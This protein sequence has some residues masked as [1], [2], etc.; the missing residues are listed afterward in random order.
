MS[1]YIV[2]GKVP[3]GTDKISSIGNLN[4][5]KSIDEETGQKSLWNP[6]IFAGM[7]IY[8]RVDPMSIHIDTAI[9]Y[10]SR[11]LYQF[12]WYFLLGGIG[13]F[14]FLKQ[15]K[16]PWY[17][18]VI[19]TVAFIMLP[20]W[21]AMLGNGHFSKIRAIMVLPWLLA[22][23]DYFIEKK[24]WFSA[25]LFALAFSWLVRTHHFQIVFYGIV[26]L[27]FLYAFPIL[28]LSIE[29]KYKD[30]GNIMLKLTAAVI[31]TIMTAA[32]PM[33]STKEYADYSTRGGNPVELGNEA[34]TAKKSG[35]VSFEYATRWSLAPREIIDFFIPRF[36]GGTSAEVY[37]GE[38]Y[39]QVKG[40]R[41]PG[42][43]GEMP[44]TDNYDAMGMILFL[45][46]VIG[47]IHFR[48]NPFVA[49]LGIF[50]LFSVLLALGRHF[51]FFYDIFFNYLPYFSK[52]RVPVMFAH[53][54]FIATFILS[55][56]GL[57]AVFEKIQKKEFNTVY[58]VL[59]G[60]ILFTI[61]ILL[62]KDSFSY[63]TPKEVQQ[64]NAATLDIIKGIREE[65]LTI[66]TRRLLIL[67]VVTAAAVLGFLFGKIK[68]EIALVVIFLLAA[69]ELFAITK[70]QVS[71]IDT[72]DPEVLESNAF[73]KTEINEYLS[74]Q[75][76]I[77]RALVI[78][79]EFQ[80]NYY[81][82]FYPTIN[83]YSAIKLQLIQDLID[84]SLFSAQTGSRINWAAANM[85][86]GKYIVSS[87]PLGEPFLEQI[88][89]SDAR[90][91]I[92]YLNKNSLP[93]AWFVKEVKTLESKEDI[94]LAINREDFQPDS[95]AYILDQNLSAKYS[96]KGKIE[97]EEYTPNKII[98][99]ISTE[100]EQFL[101]LSEVYYPAGWI[102]RIEN[103]ELKIHQTNH[104]L[105]GINV[106]AGN[107]KVVFEFSPS[108]Y[109]SS[110]TY[111]W[112]GNL[113]ILGLIIVPYLISMKKRTS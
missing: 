25:G 99:D 97:V 101:L 33:L 18:A 58:G 71:K 73:A 1:P 13:F 19:P 96:G 17:I 46:A 54:T 82:Y 4:L 6:G 8:P 93:K 72:F 80:S 57:Y 2:D 45:F 61:L 67:L 92:L 64:Y 108:T 16:I 104:I 68:R 70:R 15:R 23:F 48:N 110:L 74:N 112:I 95:I 31:L 32:H 47:L 88:A 76:P 102:A 56:Y 10:F 62:I 22:T 55:A 26:M 111:V 59:G 66:D 69:I 51:A 106:P 90:K 30:F 83:G 63:I 39:P 91:E 38:E 77:N 12:F 60:G 21:Q 40:Q 35:G 24:S 78:S 11:I 43:W 50:I 109:Y 44:F 29:K 36:T 98:L 75:E 103:E 65:F 52:F 105:R 84:H 113:L 5:V 86:N 94:V 42:Y 53:I 79:N 20:D 49:S 7:P 41:V 81:A 28:K 87:A 14:L 100:N 34:Q 107:Y 3:A 27:F 85:L 89:S 9:K 37:D